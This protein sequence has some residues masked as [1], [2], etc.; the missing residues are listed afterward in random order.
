MRGKHRTFIKAWREH[1]GLT[2]EQ[3]GERVGV[4]HGYLSKIENGERRYNQEMLESIA[5]ALNTDPA[6]LLMRDP[7]DPE[8]IWS[9]WENVPAVER[10]RAIEMLRVFTRTGTRG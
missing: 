1:R 4:S 2:Q 8:G 9:V 3:L 7:A 5:E 6:S 10:T